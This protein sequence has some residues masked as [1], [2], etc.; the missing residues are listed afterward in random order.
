MPDRPAPPAAFGAFAQALGDVAELS[1]RNDKADR[2][3]ALLADLDD[4]DLARAARW[5][6]GRVF[7]LS[8]QRTVSVGF[9]AIRKAVAAASG[10]DDD[11]LQAALVRLGDPGDVAAEAL[12]E[13]AAPPEPLTLGG[14]E[15]F[16]E[17]L[18][19]TRGSGAKTEAVADVLGRVGPEEA[20]YLVKLLAGDLRIGML[21]GGVENAL[22]R[23]YERDLGAVK[24]ANMLTGDV[25]E[26]AVLARHDRL[27]TA[28]LRL[29]HPI[30]FMLATAAE[31]TD[32]RTLA[33]EVARQIAPPFAVEDKFD[34]IRAQAHVEP[35]AQ[36]EAADAPGVDRPALH[37][38][39]VDAG[40]AAVRVALF[41]RT[42]DA[43]TRS[44]PDLTAALAALAADVPG[45]LVLDGEVVPLGEGGR[46]APFQTLQKRLGRKR[47]PQALRDEAPVGY[48]VY[49]VLA[50]D[51]EPV[52]DRGYRER[53]A[54]LDRLGLG[55]GG[56]VRRSAVQTVEDPDTLDERF[57]AARAR[58]NEGLMVKALDAPYVPGRRG[59]DWLKVKK[60]LATLDVVVTAV[61][62]GSGGRR[63]LLSDFTFAV[64]RSESDGTLLNVGKAYSGLTD[65]ELAALTEWFKA[66]TLE[67][68][69]HG[70]VRTVEP[71]VVVEVAFDNVQVS[72][73]HKGG[74]ALRFPRI[75][76]LRDDKPVGEIDTIE[77]V[78]ALAGGA[79]R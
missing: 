69:A 60:A 13:H 35:E 52:L 64:R 7:P 44:F 61:E 47:V 74:Y 15:A 76:R 33:E 54:L 79:G 6:A 3:G 72:K 41:S 16:F 29:F 55:A 34:G 39:V 1:G 36:A 24:R 51:G 66:H 49:D 8:D 22:A 9:A 46:L 75:V 2:L 56:A 27:G 59:R 12:A 23:L 77:T 30:K 53:Q 78:A 40:G 71:E 4:D 58:G 67:T 57:D 5:A 31:E 73:R 63:H 10:A 18:A 38:E 32:E 50:W 42:L 11:A 14:A 48:V 26:T 43:V 17:G 19:G 20:R 21:E 70:K 28:A 65:A 37:G 25:G 45:G 68:F 62:V